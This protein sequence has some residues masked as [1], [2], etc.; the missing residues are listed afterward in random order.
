MT[1]SPTAQYARGA[2]GKLIGQIGNFHIDGAY[3]GYALH[4]MVSEGGGVTDVLQV[5]HQ[6]KAEL[7]RLMFAFIRGMEAA[8][9]SRDGG[10]R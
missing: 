7:Q 9:E 2:D 8:T 5:G 10:A 4:R 3:G 6:S 1:G